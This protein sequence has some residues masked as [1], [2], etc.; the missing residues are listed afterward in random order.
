[1]SGETGGSSE[2]AHAALAGRDPDPIEEAERAAMFG[3]DDSAG[4]DGVAV[5]EENFAGKG[6]TP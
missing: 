6:A 4:R 1:M 3:G 5:T 2:E